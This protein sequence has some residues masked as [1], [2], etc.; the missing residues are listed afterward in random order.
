MLNT[1]I[2]RIKPTTLGYRKKEALAGILMSL[3]WILGFLLLTL[4]P[5]AFGLYSSFT[6]WDIISSP[7]WVGLEN[8]IRMFG[9]GDRLFFRALR[10]T[11]LYTLM[12]APIHIVL[13]VIIASL[14]N[15]KLK[16]TNVFRA[17]FYLPYILP[18]VATIVLWSWVFNPDFGLVNYALSLVGIEGP[19]WFADQ[20]WALFT[21]VLM[22]LQYLGFGMMVV[23]A[24]LQRVP[25][26]LYEAAEIDG[27]GWLQKFRHITLPLISPVIF[28]LTILHINGSFQ[29]FTEAFL[30]TNGGPNYRTYFYG[31][32]IYN[33]AWV[34]FR[35]GYASALA[36]ILFLLVMLITFINF[37]F[38]KNWVYTE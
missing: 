24:G 11:L 31:L 36:W 3:P 25:Q 14:L 6:K 4:G 23:L 29:T 35:M 18:V 12:S 21:I 16:G 34:S 22:N 8:Y 17:I 10:V 5:L 32:H 13:D 26:E 20:D 15:M 19:K 33:E 9:G 2:A 7:R 38:S 27:A 30:L 37:K 1:F 28:L